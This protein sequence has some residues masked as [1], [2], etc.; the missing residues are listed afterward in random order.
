MAEKKVVSIEDRI[1]K[2]KE[3]RKKKTNRR[4]IFYLSLFFILISIIVYL[5]S[6]LSYVKNINVKGNEYIDS[7]VL[8]ELSELS[9]EVNFW[10]FSTSHIEKVLVTHDEIKAAN[11]S[12]KFPNTVVIEVEELEKVA[13]FKKENQYYPLLENGQLLDTI[14]LSSWHSDAPLLMNF[15]KDV[16]IK[17]MAEELKLLP[18]AIS[19]LI[20]EIF[21]KPTESN[22]YKVIVLMND[23]FQVESTIRNFYSYMKTYPSIVNQLEEDQKGVITIG[24]GGAV[25]DPYEVK[26]KDEEDEN[27]A[28]R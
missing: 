24:E 16:Y 6:P 23:G 22:P 27:E 25:F 21:W 5:Q 10:S 18:S 1:P 20:S 14:S 19:S 7:S 4:L 17:E 11:V 13:Y 12:R 15:N 28:A 2:L 9:E 8:I 26:R 3:A